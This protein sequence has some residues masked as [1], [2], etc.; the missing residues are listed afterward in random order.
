[1]RAEHGEATDAVRRL[2]RN[3]RMPDLLDATGDLGAEMRGLQVA[4][5]GCGSV[6]LAVADIPARLGVDRLLLVDPA[7][8]K[9]VSVLT[10]PCFPQDLGRSKA[11]VAG[12]RAKAVSPNTQVLAFDGCFEEIP[13][14]LLAGTSYLLLASDNLL[15]ESSVSQAALHLGI[16]VLQ[17]SVYGR[18]LTAQVRSIVCG[19]DGQ[20]PCLCCEFGE[21]EWE[22]LDG[23][24]VFSCTGADASAGAPAKRSRVPT[25]SLPHLCRIA[26][27][28]LCMELTRRVLG[29]G[30]AEQSRVVEYSGY[31][32]R[33]AVTALRRRR[34]CPLDHS[35]LQL[36]PRARDLGESAPRELLREAGYEEDW[37]P[38]RVT[39]TVEGRSFSTL[40]VCDCSPHPTLGRFLPTGSAAGSCPRCGAQRWPHPLHTHREV[41]LSVL[42]GQLDRTL[43]SLGATEP[44]SVRLRGERGAVLFHR[45]FA[46]A[47]GGGAAR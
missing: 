39:L 25:E 38:R 11:I 15:C 13:T 12:E 46:E 47:A 30:Q 4:V 27:D 35:R 41:P 45:G 8:F 28:I 10:H 14:H 7:R 21:R 33:T 6:G 2:D 18:T 42:A 37:D 29:I 23:G 34:D 5:I 44:A 24:T 36:A 17:A 43:A 32:H 22:E 19:E 9:A 26:A 20:G 1:M 31:T 16:P 40:A 3:A